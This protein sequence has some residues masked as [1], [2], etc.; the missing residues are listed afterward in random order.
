M[1]GDYVL[2]RVAE[3]LSAQ[4]RPR[5]HSRVSAATSLWPSFRRWV[6]ST[7]GSFGAMTTDR[8]HR[9]GLTI[10][11]AIDQIERGKGTQFD[12]DLAVEFIKMVE[13][14][15]DRRSAAA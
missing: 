4:I 7:Q 8:P 14:E 6:N 3:K 1:E 9:K 10:D 15:F 2:K 5:Q 11:P 13:L 12:P